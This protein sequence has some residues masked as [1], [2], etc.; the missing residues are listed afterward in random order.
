M[1]YQLLLLLMLLSF[2]KASAQVENK[3]D[4]EPDFNDEPVLLSDV[5]NSKTGTVQKGHAQ[6]PN[7]VK[8]PTKNNQHTAVEAPP[9]HLQ[10]SSIPQMIIGQTPKSQNNSIC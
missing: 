4:Y 8:K 5:D 10:Y 1:K 3:A 2:V 7:K 6:S 9:L